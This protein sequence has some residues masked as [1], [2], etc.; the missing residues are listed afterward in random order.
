MPP[1]LITPSP[2][3]LSDEDFAA[4]ARHPLVEAHRIPGGHTLL[5]HSRDEVMA[6][7]ADFMA[8]HGYLR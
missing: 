4:Y 8:R 6:A 1:R 5:D 7:A 2:S 3:V